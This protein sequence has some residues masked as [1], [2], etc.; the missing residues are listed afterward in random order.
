MAWDVAER[1]DPTMAADLVGRAC[2]RARIS[3]GRRQPPS[4]MPT[5]AT[6]CVRPR[7]RA[8]WRSWVPGV[9]YVGGRFASKTCYPISLTP[10]NTG[11]SSCPFLSSTSADQGTA[12]AGSG[13]AAAPLVWRAGCRSD[14][15][16]RCTRRVD[17]GCRCHRPAG[18]GTPSH[19]PGQ[20][21]DR[22]A[23]QAA[24]FCEAVD[25]PG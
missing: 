3:K 13:S 11:F 22:A 8:S 6:P 4:C 24:D 17:H 15:P 14:G 21:Q 16:D 25:A 5:T 20:R 2:I 18:A 23:H 1:E 12:V 7:S 9:N 10:G 19:G